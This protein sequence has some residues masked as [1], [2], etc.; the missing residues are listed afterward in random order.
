M[1]S[2]EKKL[3]VDVAIACFY[4]I[5]MEGIN[6]HFLLVCSSSITRI[7]INEVCSANCS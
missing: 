1:N 6:L 7:C 4:S 5:G 3:S 2:T